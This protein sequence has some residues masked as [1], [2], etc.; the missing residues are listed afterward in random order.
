MI[1]EKKRKHLLDFKHS[2]EVSWKMSLLPYV[3]DRVFGDNH[4]CGQVSFDD[5]Q[6]SHLSWQARLAVDS[7]VL[8]DFQGTLGAGTVHVTYVQKEFCDLNTYTY[9]MR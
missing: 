9:L 8:F 5:G 3:M 1:S 2:N 7:A 6:A 4:D